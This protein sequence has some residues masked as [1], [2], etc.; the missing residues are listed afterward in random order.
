MKTKKRVYRSAP[1]IC[2]FPSVSTV[3]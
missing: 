1:R 3:T 2:A